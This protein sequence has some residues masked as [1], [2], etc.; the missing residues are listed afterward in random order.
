M[1]ELINQTA[2]QI[3]S[4]KKSYSHLNNSISFDSFFNELFELEI[5]KNSV[6]SNTEL[7]LLFKNKNRNIKK[8]K[9]SIVYN[10]LTKSFVGEFG[11]KPTTIQT[12][13][14]FLDN[15]YK[16][17]TFRL[18]DK[19]NA[20]LLEAQGFFDCSKPNTVKKPVYD[21]YGNYSSFKDY[22]LHITYSLCDWVNDDTKL[23]CSYHY[24][25]FLS[26]LK[27]KSYIKRDIEFIA[28]KNLKQKLGNLIPMV[29][30][31]NDTTNDS[32]VLNKLD[33]SVN[34]NMVVSSSDSKMYSRVDYSNRKGMPANNIANNLLLRSITQV[35]SVETITTTIDFTNVHQQAKSL[36]LTQ[37][38]PS[39]KYFNQLDFD[40]T[41][42]LI[43]LADGLHSDDFFKSR[44]LYC[45]LNEIVK[46][47][48]EF[49]YKSKGKIYKN[50]YESLLK[51]TS[52]SSQ[53]HNSNTKETINHT[54]FKADI[55]RT[56]NFEINSNLL[57]N[58]HNIVKNKYGNLFVKVEF[59][60][61]YINSL[62]ETAVFIDK[63]ITC[64]LRLTNSLIAP[65]QAKRYSTINSG[66]LHQKLEYSTYFNVI[67]ML[68]PR[69]RK[70]N[71]NDIEKA[72]Q[73]L[74]ENKTIIADYKVKG[75]TF[76]IE[77]LPMEKL[78]LKRI[79]NAIS[80]YQSRGL[81]KNTIP[82]VPN[83]R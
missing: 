28:L 25:S 81:F 51:I 20:D 54:I 76:L 45:H 15:F 12:F 31:D 17:C 49:G 75:S 4:V 80:H 68:N 2:L 61:G 57:T 8:T 34:S 43:E 65:L 73:E 33:S 9:V 14:S 24:F 29:V 59:S 77:F 35:S 47:L 66:S 1:E 36:S 32:N 44:V 72:L 40:V 26:V 63:K 7:S 78:E 62:L 55:T 42:A 52:Y 83:L 5:D 6:L 23:L 67:L 48:L 79:S 69:K 30:T 22:C 53:Y 27:K 58:E 11:K 74:K 60:S 21:I 3:N 19:A 56:P 10:F 18:N 70:D 38:A 50:V 46:K 82:S 71:I 16:L 13:N 41:R 64:N 37:D 39:I